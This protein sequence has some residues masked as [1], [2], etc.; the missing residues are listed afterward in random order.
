MDRDDI[1][2]SDLFI[3]YRELHLVNKWLGGYR[4]T[5]KGLST[6]L[7]DRKCSY[8]ILDVGCGGGDMV[9]SVIKWGCKENLNV[10]LT[11]VDLNPAAIEYSKM[12]EPR[13]TWLQQD[14][15][16]HLASGVKYNLIMSTLFMHHFTKNKIVELLRL[17]VKSCSAG[18][19]INDLHRNPVAYY[20]IKILTGFLSKSYL[21]KHDAPLS[22]LRAFSKHEWQLILNEAGIKKA[23]IQWCWAFRHLIIIRGSEAL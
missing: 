9:K 17:M 13:C 1:P 4:I 18:I 22:V 12:N 19:I 7:T 2:A 10:T 21:V 11:G 23:T 14:I 8:S 6:L 15:F 5:L 3:N 16:D 20:S